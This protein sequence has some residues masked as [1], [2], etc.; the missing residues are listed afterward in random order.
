[1][2]RSKHKHDKKESKPKSSS[3]KQAHKTEAPEPSLQEVVKT[4]YGKLLQGA[5]LK[6]KEN[7]KIIRE[8]EAEN[9]Q[10]EQKA[11][12]LMRSNKVD[13]KQIELLLQIA[14]THVN[15]TIDSGR[16]AILNIS[17]GKS[18]AALYS[19]EVMKHVTPL[20]N[21]E[22]NLSKELT[23]VEDNPGNYA[24]IYESYKKN[25][26]VKDAKIEKD[27]QL[28]RTSLQTVN[29]FLNHEKTVKFLAWDARRTASAQSPIFAQNST[30]KPQTQ[31]SEATYSGVRKKN[32]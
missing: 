30:T 2:F 29:E 17:L 13:E 28:I 15:Q 32:N 27:D 23:P 10:L 12:Q 20:Q 25:S 18:N 8:L 3:K 4:T 31:N 21:L 7:E 14:E 16:D 22:K 6:E 26:Q 9:A 24:A 19:Q 5:Q 11:T 1:M